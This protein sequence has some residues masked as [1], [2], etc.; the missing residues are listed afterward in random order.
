M[1]SDEEKARMVRSFTLGIEKLCTATNMLG[2]GLDAVGVRVVIHVAMCPLLLQYVQES[3]RAGRT[4][5]D[6]DSIVLRACYLTKEG[7]VKKTLGY[8]LEQPAK[9]FLTEQAA[10]RARRVEV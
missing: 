1:G 5:L 7:S 10:M 6:S 2:L 3:G 4:G 8:K 9:E